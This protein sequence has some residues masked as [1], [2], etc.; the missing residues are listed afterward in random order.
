MEKVT[1][2]RLAEYSAAHLSQ[3]KYEPRNNLW[4]NLQIYVRSDC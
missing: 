1:P 3:K 2:I 4:A